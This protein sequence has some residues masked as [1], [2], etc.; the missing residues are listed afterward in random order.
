MI[1][2]SR[3]REREKLRHHKRSTSLQHHGARILTKP[4]KSRERTRTSSLPVLSLK[5]KSELREEMWILRAYHRNPASCGSHMVEP[6]PLQ[7][8]CDNGTAH[9]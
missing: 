4:S 2:G 9:S 7:P 5:T 3:V 8:A 1:K 6:P